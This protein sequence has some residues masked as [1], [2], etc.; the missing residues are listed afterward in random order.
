[1]PTNTCPS[2]LE[3][4]NRPS[5]C[6]TTAGGIVTELLYALK[7]DVETFPDKEQYSTRTVLSGHIDTANGENI[8]M[9]H[10]KRMFKMNV[11]KNSAELKYAMQGESGSRSF[12]T[13]LEV[14]APSMRATVLGFLAETANQ[15]LIILAKTR[16]GDW[17]L[18]GDA[19]E[20]VEYESAE[21]ATGKNGS[22]ANGVTIT[23]STTCA[24]P[25]IYKGTVEDLTEAVQA[26]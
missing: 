11:K 7:T 22:D 20:G 15:E 9:K 19:D 26:E 21:A 13:T 24:A 2:C 14:Y 23:F 8:V 12:K 3:D 16:S 18:I 10:G 1:M 5:V 17:H 6:E 25:T 4:L